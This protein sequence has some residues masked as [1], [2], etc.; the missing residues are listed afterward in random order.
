MK[1]TTKYVGAT[2]TRGSHFRATIRGALPGVTPVQVTVPYDYALDSWENHEAAARACISRL[3]A[4]LVE[5]GGAANKLDGT[6]QHVRQTSEGTVYATG[7]LTVKAKVVF[8]LVFGD[9]S[10]GGDE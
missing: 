10:D 9:Y 3:H 1:V 7:R 5:I 4:K 6:W 8:D 2:D